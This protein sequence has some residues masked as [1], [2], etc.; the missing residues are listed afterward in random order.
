MH[1]YYF[2]VQTSQSTVP[3]QMTGF[4][5]VPETL[6]PLAITATLLQPQLDLDSVFLH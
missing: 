3:A 5:T 1:G 6:G 2:A 4:E